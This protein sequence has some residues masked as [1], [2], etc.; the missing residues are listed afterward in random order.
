[1]A[2]DSSY[3]KRYKARRVYV[4]PAP[5]KGAYASLADDASEEVLGEVALNNRTRLAVSMFLSKDDGQPR[6]VEIHLLKFRTNS[7][8]YHE[9]SIRFNGFEAAKLEELLTIMASL[10]LD[11][12]QTQR[13]DLG[14]ISPDQFFNFQNKS[15]LVRR[16]SNDER[17]EA[18]VFAIAKKRSVLRKFKIL[19]DSETS[20]NEWQE[21]LEDNPW[22]FGFGLNYVF[23]D[24]VSKKFETTTTGSDFLTP[25]KRADGLAMTKA[26]VSQ[27]VLI[28]IKASKSPLLQF[29]PYRSGVWPV[30]SEVSAAVSQSQK[31]VF[32]FVRQNSVKLELADDVGKETGTT[33]YNVEPRAYLIVGN[34]AELE[35]NND[36][37]TSFELFRRKLMSPEILTFDELYYRAVALVESISNAKN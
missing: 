27:T 9:E 32:E 24:R 37:I 25:G 7:G 2:S 36:K 13:F 31:T 23:L 21:F 5:G 15:D 20:E 35:G 12:N 10:K 18:D 33:T 14:T 1:M 16:I 28:E 11:P 26:R 34:L 4:N 6:T 22:I 19:L 8:W 30:A 29:K 17:L 3:I